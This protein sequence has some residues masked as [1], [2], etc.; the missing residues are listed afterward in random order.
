MI[1]QQKLYN[2]YLLKSSVFHSLNWI[3]IKMGKQAGAVNNNQRALPGPMGRPGQA[4]PVKEDK[5][6]P[7]RPP[8]K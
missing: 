8:A 1:Y 3:A 4:L 7:V 5:Y 2:N 6:F